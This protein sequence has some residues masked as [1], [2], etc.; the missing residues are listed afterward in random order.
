MR[1][2]APRCVYSAGAGRARREGGAEQ[3]LGLGGACRRE[4]AR[5]TFVRRCASPCRWGAV[6]LETT[7]SP[8]RRPSTTCRALAGCE[9]QAV[10]RALAKSTLHWRPCVLAEFRAHRSRAWW[11]LWPSPPLSG[12]SWLRLRLSAVR[13]TG[14]CLP[15]SQ[16]GAASPG[17]LVA[18][19]RGTGR[20]R[21]APGCR[22]L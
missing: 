10:P 3:I 8:R 11:W 9:R 21:A 2:T 17:C 13:L 19:G 15:A 20:V 12:E 22:H 1:G 5:S 14:C 18:V 4:A 16:P 6:G 7:G